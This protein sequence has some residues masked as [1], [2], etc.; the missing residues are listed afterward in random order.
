MEDFMSSDEAEQTVQQIK[1]LAHFISTASGFFSLAEL[2]T[3]SN[4]NNM[5]VQN[6]VNPTTDVNPINIINITD[7]PNIMNIT[8]DN[9]HFLSMQ[10][11]AETVLASGTIGQQSQV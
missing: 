2:A 8:E 10:S 7:Q 9:N 1:A 4:L 6:L 3:T 5:S 11:V